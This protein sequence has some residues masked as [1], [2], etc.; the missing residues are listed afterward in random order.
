MG[1]TSF[2]AQFTGPRVKEISTQQRTRSATTPNGR[3]TS[4]YYSEPSF[5]SGVVLTQPSVRDDKTSKRKSQALGSVKAKSNGNAAKRKSW[6]GTAKSSEDRPAM[7]TLPASYAGPLGGHRELDTPSDG[8]AQAPTINDGFYERPAARADG[9]ERESRRM[10]ISRALGIKRSESASAPNDRQKRRSW[11]GGAADTDEDIPP[12]PPMPIIVPAVVKENADLKGRR[13]S[14]GGTTGRP[15]SKSETA[16]RTSK[17]R[18]WFQSSNPDDEDVPQVPA[19][20]GLT[21]DSSVTSDGRTA[22]ARSSG[23]D[24]LLS[25]PENPYRT[26][27]RGNSMRQPRPVSMT[28]RRSYT[29]KYADKSFL[30]TTGTAGD[31]SAR[32]SFSQP[33]YVDEEMYQ[34]VTLSNEQ[35]QEWDKLKNLMQVMEQRQDDGVFSMLREL[36]DD[37][38]NESRQIYSNAQALAALDWQH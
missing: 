28:H 4:K 8:P 33:T 32:K 38:E 34:R 19:L 20:P 35:Q 9:D 15:R 37:E 5:T 3:V 30:K 21:Y 10:S 11:F 26:V 25:D 36:E 31:S 23:H 12:L 18:S 7:P 27:T 22:S 2:W 16:A 17:R 29:P 1:L 24:H 6:F 13:K 14:V